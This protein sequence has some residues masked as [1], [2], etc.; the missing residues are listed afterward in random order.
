MELDV[1]HAAPHPHP[2]PHHRKIELQ[3]PLDLAYLERNMSVA[4]REKLD[5]HFPPSASSSSS[6]SAP[7]APPPATEIAAPA[8]PDP[9]RQRVEDLV[10]QFLERMWCAAK[11][12]ITVNGQD[13][14]TTTTRKNWPMTTNEMTPTLMP[15]LVRMVKRLRSNRRCLGG[16]R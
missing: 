4:A 2:H 12:N 13:A 3:S 11:D 15:L 6:S 14:A 8:A 7:H 10:A 1:P 16:S 9:M 5:L